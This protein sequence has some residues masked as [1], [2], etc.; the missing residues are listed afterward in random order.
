MYAIRDFIEQHIAETHSLIDLA[1]R[2]GTNEYALKKDSKKYLILLFS[3]IGAVLKCRMQ[4]LILEES[5]HIN[6]I[7]MT[8]GYKTQGIFQQL[9]KHFGQTPTELKSK[10]KSN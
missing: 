5:L 6:E 4:K 7:A 8:V 10:V 1:H 9:Q 3:T 2:F